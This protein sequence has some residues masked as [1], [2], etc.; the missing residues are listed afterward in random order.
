MI[1]A[2]IFEP[3]D[4]NPPP[5]RNSAETLRNNSAKPPNDFS[6]NLPK[7]F[8]VKTEK[9]KSSLYFD[10]ETAGRLD[11]A[12]ALLKR[13]TGKR[14]HEISRSVVI[15]AAIN[16]VLDQLDELGEESELVQKLTE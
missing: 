10:V 11:V 1:G 8:S 9:V 4:P 3:T 5:R 16:I 7:S 2:D 6:A 14:G 12:H 15:E 13:L